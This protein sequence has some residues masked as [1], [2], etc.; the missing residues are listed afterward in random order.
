MHM[1]RDGLGDGIVFVVVN[2][3]IGREIEGSLQKQWLIDP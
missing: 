3:S 2:L 1:L